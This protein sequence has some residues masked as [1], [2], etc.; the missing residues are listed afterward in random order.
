[1][2]IISSI[3]KLLGKLSKLQKLILGIAIG[4]FVYV[5][6]IKVEKF[7][8]D[9]EDEPVKTG[10]FDMMAQNIGL[11]TENTLKAERQ[12]E[13]IADEYMKYDGEDENIRKALAIAD[14]YK[15]Y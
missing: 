7:F 8:N 11:E 10:I 1:M 9:V 5:S 13:A 14:D 6:Y 12:E 2:K 3:N 15:K 4:Y